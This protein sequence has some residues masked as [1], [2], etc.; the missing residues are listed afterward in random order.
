MIIYRP[1]AVTAEQIKEV[2]GPVELYCGDKALRE[3]PI[4]TLPSPGVGMRHYAPRARLVLIE[5]QAGAPDHEL[6][7]RLAE[8]AAGERGQRLGVMLPGGIDAPRE[9]AATR[10]YPWGVWGVPESLAQGLYAGLRALDAARCTVILCPLPP[11]NG[12]GT[13]IRDRLRKAGSKG[14]R[15]RES[16]NRG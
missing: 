4:E 14:A 8:A 16:R 13:A 10:I 5:T 1:G 9:I 7:R 12:L 15:E 11:A 6:E 3:T 2:A